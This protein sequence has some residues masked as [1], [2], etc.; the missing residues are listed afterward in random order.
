MIRYLLLLL[1]LLLSCGVSRTSV[2]PSGLTMMRS[3]LYFGLSKRSGGVVA[4]QE[5]A[6]FVDTA[7]TPRFPDGLS[8]VDAAGQY[9]MSSG[10]L[11]KERTKIVLIVHPASPALDS[12][13]VA[14]C[15]SYAR[16][17]DQESVMKV[18]GVC[19]VEFVGD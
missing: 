3:E 17:F 11:Q 5:W 9:R 18:S 1:P 16:S 10:A 14:I 4:E 19:V 13:L 15:R 6:R 2:L 12:S 7:I 8:I